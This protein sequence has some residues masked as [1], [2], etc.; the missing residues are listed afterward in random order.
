MTFLVGFIYNINIDE[1]PLVGIVISTDILG[2]PFFDQSFFDQHKAKYANQYSNSIIQDVGREVPQALVR[3]AIPVGQSDRD[4]QI[5]EVG[6]HLRD[7]LLGCVEHPDLPWPGR[8]F[9]ESFDE[10]D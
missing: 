5:D 9:P 4:G 10:E 8:T 6:Q 1:D 3:T 7:A 2:L